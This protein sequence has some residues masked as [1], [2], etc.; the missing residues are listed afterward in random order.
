MTVAYNDFIGAKV[1]IADAT[2]LPCEPCD[3]H[4]ALKPHQRD[5][6]AWAVRGG[7]RA[8][9][10]AFGLGK[11]LMQLEIIRLT[12]EKSGGKLGLIIPSRRVA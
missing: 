1:A 11:T 10:C 6:V 9:F 12:L 5:M 8:I 7:Q 3:T 4:P 2:G